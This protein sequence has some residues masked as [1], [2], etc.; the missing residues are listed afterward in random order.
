MIAF[1]LAKTSVGVKERFYKATGA[2]PH[3]GMGFEVSVIL[4]L[5]SES[6]RPMRVDLHR[7]RFGALLATLQLNLIIAEK[8]KLFANA[9]NHNIG[10]ET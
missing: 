3:D 5:P 7:L 9:S 6:R 10:R 1:S 8:E 4:R 2:S